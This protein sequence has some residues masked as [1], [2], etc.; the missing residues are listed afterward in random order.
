M[1]WEPWMAED[2]R[3]RDMARQE[4]ALPDFASMKDHE[5]LECLGDDGAM[6][7]AAFCQIAKQHGQDI[8]EGW[9][10]GWFANC[11]EASW[12]KR[13]ARAQPETQPEPS[14]HWRG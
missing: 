7:A 3:Q 9:M 6:W 10:I 11:I 1:R 12:A 14:C 8:D 2:E 13:T 5:L 4:R